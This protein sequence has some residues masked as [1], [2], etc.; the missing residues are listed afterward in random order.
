MALKALLHTW[1]KPGGGAGSPSNSDEP[2][3]AGTYSSSH[4]ASVSENGVNTRD[5]GLRGGERDDGT[6]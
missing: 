1:W 5:A 6:V 2:G 3:D 4:E